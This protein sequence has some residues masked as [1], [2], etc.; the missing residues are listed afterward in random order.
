MPR[1]RFMVVAALVLLPCAAASQEA[2]TLPPEVTP[3]RLALARQLLRVSGYK[4]SVLAGLTAGLDAQI[5]GNPEIAAH[6][7]LALLRRAGEEWGMSVLNSEDATTAFASIYAEIF[8]EAEL[9]DLN[10]FFRTPTGQ[11]LAAEQVNIVARSG[12]VVAHLA[13]LRRPELEARLLSILG[14]P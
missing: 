10:A 5:A 1:I 3:E 11:R 12:P 4:Q 6:P 7:D 8:T 13:E 2:R 14:K 9:R